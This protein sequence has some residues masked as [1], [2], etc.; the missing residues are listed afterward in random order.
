MKPELDNKNDYGLLILN[1]K[2]ISY[3]SIFFDSNKSSYKCYIKYGFQL[4][5]HRLTVMGVTPRRST[6]PEQNLYS[7]SSKYGKSDKS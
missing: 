2:V 7:I 3:F 6:L 5:Y 1:E 4:M